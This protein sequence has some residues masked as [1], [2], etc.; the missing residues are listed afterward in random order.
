KPLV[1]RPGDDEAEG[2]IVELI[3]QLEYSVLLTAHKAEWQTAASVVLPVAAWSEE[4]GTYTTFEG[5]VQSAGNAIEP[6]ADALPGW[7][8]FAMLLHASGAASPWMSAEDVFATMTEC[9]PAY[10]GITLEQTRLPGA[11]VG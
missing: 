3:E 8:V 7:E 9:E 6:V 2:R 4:E 5:R 11:I 10:R 1:P